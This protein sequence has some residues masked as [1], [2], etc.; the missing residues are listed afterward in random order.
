M[1][2]YYWELK[3]AMDDDKLVVFC[4]AGTS[5]YLGL[6]SWKDLT[7]NIVQKTKRYSR[8]Y[9]CL[10][11]LLRNDTI[12]PLFI[13]DL[14]EDDYRSLIVKELSDRIKLDRKQDFERQKKILKITERVITSNYDKA[15]E[16]AS[17]SPN[18]IMNDGKFKLARIADNKKFIFKIHGDI[19]NPED[20]ILFT[21]QYEELYRDSAFLLGLKMLFI[22]KTILFIGFSLNDP[23][24][25]HIINSITQTF[26]AFNRRHFIVTTDK[27]FDTYRFKKVVKPILLRRYSELDVFLNTLISLK[28][29]GVQSL[30]SVHNLKNSPANFSIWD[31]RQLEDIIQLILNLQPVTVILGPSGS[32]KTSL[33]QEVAYLCLGRS[34]IEVRNPIRFE[35][36]VWI[37]TCDFTDPNKIL[38]AVFDEIGRVTGYLRI[39]FIN[40]SEI[41]AK[42]YAVNKILADLPVLII[43]D[44]FDLHKNEPLS[45]W[46]QQIA[47]PSEV[48]LTSQ[49]PPNFKHN[50]YPLKGFSEETFRKIL[51]QELKFSEVNFTPDERTLKSLFTISSGN[52]QVILLIIGLLRHRNSIKVPNDQKRDLRS[53]FRLLY[54]IS[55]DALEKSRALL[56]YISLLTQKNGIP[57]EALKEVCGWDWKDFNDA[58]KELADWNLLVIDQHDKYCQIHP[59]LITFLAEKAKEG[60]EGAPMGEQT[61]AQSEIKIKF[62]NYYLKLVK[63]IIKREFPDETYW[64]SL[65]SPSMDLLDDHWSF[66]EQAIKWTMEIPEAADHLC[67]LANYLVHYMDSRFYN[68]FRIE[69][70]LAAIEACKSK[71]RYFQE[72]LFK[73]DALG[74]TCVEEDELDKA[75]AYILEGKQLLEAH[76]QTDP[77]KNDLEALSC[78]WLARVEIERPNW[79]CSKAKEFIEKALDKKSSCEPWILYRIYM[80]AGDVCYKTNDISGC[81]SHYRDAKTEIN[82]YGGE[83]GNYQINPRLGLAY[84]RVGTERALTEAAKIF[85][86]VRQNNKILIGRLYGEYGLA[87]VAYQRGN[88][89]EAKEQV[90]RVE[91]EICKRSPKNLLLKLIRQYKAEH[92]N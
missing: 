6:P 60:H 47:P 11:D 74:W 92:F 81:L 62:I 51:V 70:I 35:Y 78:A 61:E 84:L 15:F 71:R 36:V 16:Y 8:Q 40:E 3:E 52:P 14:L 37:S 27:K 67:K 12:S 23:Y 44:N 22:Q 34:S 46:I 65:V 41:K 72:A 58:L 90:L 54:N 55:Y 32:G 69:M 66:V 26:G 83:G 33:A 39:T 57:R 48:L 77:G 20:C 9:R 49:V 76:C 5:Q 73:I 43:I 31:K 24:I 68:S 1:E 21:R 63:K 53:T 87:L 7:L 89:E 29:Q 38:N 86:A 10:E 80:V 17:D 91:E 59:T 18:V 82:N 64:N 42:E 85:E 75:E 79:K 45:R 2:D 25:E 4:G 19:D 88:K 13:L 28:N 50:P 30:D 56:S